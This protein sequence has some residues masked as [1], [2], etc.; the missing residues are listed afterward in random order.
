MSRFDF[1]VHG[2]V[3]FSY[4]AIPDFMITAPLS[5]KTAVG[6]QQQLLQSWGEACHFNAVSPP[7]YVRYAGEKQFH[8]LQDI[9]G[10]IPVI[11]E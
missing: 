8:H 10:S 2:K 11:P 1:S 6:I 3:N 5:H 9:L 4:R 7:H